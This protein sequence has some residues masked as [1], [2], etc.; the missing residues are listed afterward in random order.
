MKRGRNGVHY[1]IK[2]CKAE[3][4]FFSKVHSHEK[5]L[6]REHVILGLVRKKRGSTIKKKKKKGKNSGSCKTP[7][8]VLL[9]SQSCTRGELPLFRR[10][11]R[12]RQN[13]LEPQQI[14]PTPSTRR[15]L[16][17]AVP[18]YLSAKAGSQTPG[19]Y[20]L[21]ILSLNPNYNLFILFVNCALPTIFESMTNYIIDFISLSVEKTSK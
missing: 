16:P 18:L 17:R 21:V 20:T 8:G 7:S 11:A 14:G 3:I 12:R 5:T 9:S 15:L 2:T 6:T 13:S 1:I 10:V 4:F 19:I